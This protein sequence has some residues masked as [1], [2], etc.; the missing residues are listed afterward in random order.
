MTVDR[1]LQF[2]PS[3]DERYRLDRWL[4][5]TGTKPLHA[6]DVDHLDRFAAYLAKVTPGSGNNPKTRRVKRYAPKTIRDTLQATMRVHERIYNPN[7]VDARP[8]RQD[9][10]RDVLTGPDPQ[11]RS[12]DPHGRSAHPAVPPRLSDDWMNV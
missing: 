9:K 11:S 1:W 6:I 12:V 5:F 10:P 4:R 8:R 3:V 2:K 7:L